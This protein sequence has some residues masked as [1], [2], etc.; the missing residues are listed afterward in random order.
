MNLGILQKDE[1]EFIISSLEKNDG[2]NEEEYK[3][4][5]LKHPYA[6]EIEDNDLI[7]STMKH[8][9]LSDNKLN[10]FILNKFGNKDYE[11]DFFYELIYGVGTIRTHIEIKRYVLR[12]P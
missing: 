10:E 7:I 5:S 6:V 8:Y 4:H 1:F 2:M 12:P 3:L 9:N 11:I